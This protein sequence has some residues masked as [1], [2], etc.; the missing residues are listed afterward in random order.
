MPIGFLSLAIYSVFS[1]L[2]VCGIPNALLAIATATLIS[3]KL[4]FGPALG[5]SSFIAFMALVTGGGCAFL[6][7]KS[8]LRDWAKKLARGSQ[9]LRALDTALNRDGVK[10]SALM[11]TSLP[12]T[13]VN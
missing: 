13:I 11:R 8:I 9:V 10:V 2:V 7:G 6:L 3:Q 4:D 12:H 1:S 5:L